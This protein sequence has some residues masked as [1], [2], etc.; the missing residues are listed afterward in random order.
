MLIVSYNKGRLG[1]RL[2][3]FAHFIV[4]SIK[5]K[6]SVLCLFFNEYSKYFIGTHVNHI[7]LYPPKKLMLSNAFLRRFLNFLFFKIERTAIKLNFINKY[8][9]SNYVPDFKGENDTTN[10]SVNVLIERI[11]R[12]KLSVTFYNG[13]YFWYDNTDLSE[14]KKEI[15]A[16][17]KPI[18]RIDNKVNDFIKNER[19]GFDLLCGI[20]IRR[21]D[22]K[23][24]VD[25]KFYFDNEVYISKIRE[26]KL[27]FNEKKIKF[28]IV[29][30]ENIEIADSIV[31]ELVIVSGIGDVIEDLYTL[32][33]CDYIIATPSTFSMWASFYGDVPLFT[34]REKENQVNLNRF[35]IVKDRT[36]E[37]MFD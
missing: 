15:R 7:G 11:K 26:M 31:K 8:L 16:Y 18:K 29:S 3:F 1:N 12:N 30:D 20:H 22:Y 21:G 33:S 37:F 2:F 13:G 24:F 32:A 35:Q 19:V 14:Y 27:L 4:Y 34:F 28:I 5:T 36:D 10:Y 23:S 17:F 6:E 9:F 25:G